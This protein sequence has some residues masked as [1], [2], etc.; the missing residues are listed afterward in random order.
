ME[1]DRS[2]RTL[3][4]ERARRGDAASFE[5]LLSRYQQMAFAYALSLLRDYY[6]AQDATQEALFIAYLNLANLNDPA[7]FPGWLRG[8]VHHQCCRYL[9]RRHVDLAPLDEAIG[10]PEA[11]IGP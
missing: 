3:R 5:E 8:I 6:L 4:V 2:D 1:A 9:R 7:A 11:A 10:V